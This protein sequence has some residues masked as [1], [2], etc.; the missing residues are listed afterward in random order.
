MG[1]HAPKALS[2]L[3]HALGGSVISLHV[4]A[5]PIEDKSEKTTSDL[6]AGSL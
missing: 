3:L 5:I 2:L 6:L 1:Q 4:A